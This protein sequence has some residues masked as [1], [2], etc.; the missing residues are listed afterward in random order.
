MIWRV[1]DSS[2][3]RF[4]F[5]SVLALELSLLGLLASAFILYTLNATIAMYVHAALI[6]AVLGTLTGLIL[7]TLF[8]FVIQLTSRRHQRYH[9][10]QIDEWLNRWL[11]LVVFNSG[12]ALPPAPLSLPAIEA[13]IRL[14]DVM[15][16]AQMVALH[17]LFER[18]QLL[19]SL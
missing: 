6:A 10:Q 7:L 16:G 3:Y 8:G 13:L 18:Y 9:E 19:F 5:L 4:I 2:W 12:D 14:Q 11:D 15:G 17:D 1:A